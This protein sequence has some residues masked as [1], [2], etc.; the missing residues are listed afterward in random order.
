MNYAKGENFEC[1]LIR[2]NKLIRNLQILKK[3]SERFNNEKNQQDHRFDNTIQIEGQ[4]IKSYGSKYFGQ[5]QYGN[6]EGRGILILSDGSKY[7][8]IYF[9][10]M[11]VNSKIASLMGKEPFNRMMILFIQ[12]LLQKDKF[13]DL[14]SI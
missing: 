3:I 10:D 4:E 12:E 5:F 11:R 6:K 1:N 2:K 9:L 14:V 13:Q 7:D 8:N